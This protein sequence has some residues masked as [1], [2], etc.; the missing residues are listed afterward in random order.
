[1]T[2]SPSYVWE[3]TD[4]TVT[5][6]ASIQGLSKRGANVFAT[7]ALL[8]VNAFP[9][10]LLLDL[11]KDV[12]E[13]RSSATVDQHGVTFVLV[14]VCRHRVSTKWGP[15]KHPTSRTALNLS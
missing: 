13:L 11:F 12:D 6:R 1:M 3:E 10:F 14:K 2:I 15:F 9:Y 8:K 7:S 4:T 5:V